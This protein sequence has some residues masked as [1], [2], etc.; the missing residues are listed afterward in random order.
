MA[1]WTNST[2]HET[3]LNVLFHKFRFGLFG[4]PVQI[5]HDTF[6][7]PVPSKQDLFVLPA[8]FLPR[9]IRGDM[10]FAGDVSEDFVVVGRPRPFP[11]VRPGGDGVGPRLE[12]PFRDGK[13]FVRHHQ[14]FI[15]LELGSQPFALGASPVRTVEREKPRLNLRKGQPAMDAGVVFAQEDFFFEMRRRKKEPT[16]GIL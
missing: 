11:A 16:R 7:L 13:I 1:N 15:H 12:R 10:V 14:V 5:V 3:L 4:T 6:K 2:G 9:A 8:Q